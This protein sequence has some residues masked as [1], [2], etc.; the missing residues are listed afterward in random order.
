[1][2]SSAAHIYSFK[3][4]L[5]VSTSIKIL[6]SREGHFSGISHLKGD[7]VTYDWNGLSW[8]I[9]MFLE[10]YIW[11]AIAVVIVTLASKVN[12][13]VPQKKKRYARLSKWT[14]L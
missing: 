3:G 7:L 4:S 13:L 8:T 9:G 6:S 10:R 14:C 2:C 5:P 12:I 1:M 11:F